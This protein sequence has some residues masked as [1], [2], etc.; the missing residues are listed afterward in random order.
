MK[1]GTTSK[2]HGQLAVMECIDPLLLLETI[3]VG[4]TRVSNN[5][6][7]IFTPSSVERSAALS[8]SLRLM[9]PQ[10]TVHAV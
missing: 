3:G 10:L 8:Y 9:I 2:D 5:S 1:E 6:I 7:P 4:A